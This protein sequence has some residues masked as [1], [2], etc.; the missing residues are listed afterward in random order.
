MPG[1]AKGKRVR[2]LL[3]NGCDSHNL[4]PQGWPADTID[5]TL[6]QPPHPFQVRAWKV[7]E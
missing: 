2:V 1:D 5:W 7:I 6:G 3:H 4:T